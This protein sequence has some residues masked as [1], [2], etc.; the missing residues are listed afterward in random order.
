MITSAVREFLRLESASG[1]LLLAAAA[2]ALVA[3]NSP[4]SAWY[5]ALLGTPVEVRIGALEIAKPL[6][7]WIDDG[8]M[9]IFF[10]LVGLEVKREVLEGHLSQPAEVALPAFAA[11]GGMAV[12][13]LLFSLVNHGD[14]VAMRGW[15]IPTA[16]DI[17]F[18]LGVLALLG[19]RV[20]P[21]LK[22][23]L[24][25]LA[26]LDDLG[27]IVIIAAFYTSDL[28][29]DSLVVAGVAIAV[30]AAMNRA[31]VART[32]AYLLVG[33]VLW[34]SVLKSGVHA[35]LAGVALAFFIPLEVPGEGGSP[36]RSLERDL[37]PPVA[38]GILPVFAFA[39]AG[40]SLEGV[41]LDSLLHP[42]PLGIAIGLFVGKQAGVF[43]AAWLAVRL[44]IAALPEGVSWSALYGVALLCGVGFT[45]SLFISMLAFEAGGGARVV[46]DRLGILIGSGLSAVAGYLV[47]RWVLARRP[48]S[49]GG[50]SQAR[51]S[52]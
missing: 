7:L 8:L 39:N 43:G 22:V 51:G 30:L 3:A 41:G 20:P 21:A 29:L 50:P 25:T 9:A 15:A 5:G 12:P 40:I 48:P 4:L 32:S 42:V 45:M 19:E 13:A 27:A 10:L 35:T 28:A 33:V 36:L 44:R 38:Y 23:F 2:L 18:A 24:L 37:H 47:L 16:T 26:I 1:I 49:V 17:A 6:L 31:G 34:V 14:P 11:I 46:D 52:S